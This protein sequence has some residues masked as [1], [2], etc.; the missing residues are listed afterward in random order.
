MPRVTTLQTPR[1]PL[2]SPR[3]SWLGS[4]GLLSP[5]RTARE[6]S[7]GVR[8]RTQRM[9]LSPHRLPRLVRHVV[10]M[11]LGDNCATVAAKV[12]AVCSR[13]GR[14]QVSYSHTG[15]RCGSYREGVP[16]P[17]PWKRCDGN[18]GDHGAF[19]MNPPGTAGVVHSTCKLAVLV[20]I[21]GYPQ[22]F[23]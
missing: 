17:P 5:D 2:R 18:H 10:C 23:S 21:T 3:S 14:V 4:T 9:T 15:N 13:S 8:R 12:L 19:G 20:A 11:A 22:R 1:L 6:L 16:P 7:L